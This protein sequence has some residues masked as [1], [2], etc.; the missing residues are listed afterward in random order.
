MSG[1]GAVRW[2]C[3]VGAVGT[4]VFA[5]RVTEAVLAPGD[6]VAGSGPALRQ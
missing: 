3:P 4:Y 5:W 6:T 1:K 2:A